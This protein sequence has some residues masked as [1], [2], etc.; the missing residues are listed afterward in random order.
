LEASPKKLHL[1]ALQSGVSEASAHVA[2]K[3]LNFSHEKLE[4]YKY[5][6]QQTGKQKLVLQVV[7]GG[8][9]Q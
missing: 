3:F 8:S 7:S 5:S 1:L 6:F 2:T 9:G 4:A